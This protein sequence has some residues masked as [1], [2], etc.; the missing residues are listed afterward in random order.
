[1]MLTR[2]HGA[3]QPGIET[4]IRC[5][6]FAAALYYFGYNLME[7]HRTLRRSPAVAAGATD[8]LGEVEDFAAL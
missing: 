7:V 8:R 3:S 6:H 4:V 5:F 2:L 1:M